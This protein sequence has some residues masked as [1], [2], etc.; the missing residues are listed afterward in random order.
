MLHA[1]QKIIKIYIPFFQWNFKQKINIDMPE[2]FSTIFF[3]LYR[4]PRD[5][6]TCL[7]IVKVPIILLIYIYI[8]ISINELI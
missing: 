6:Y 1:K 3:N 4:N 2:A 7:K 8:Y 5:I